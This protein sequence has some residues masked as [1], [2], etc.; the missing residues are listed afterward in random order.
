MSYLW[1]PSCLSQDQKL[2]RQCLLP[3]TYQVKFG[4]FVIFVIFVRLV[5]VTF[6]TFVSTHDYEYDDD[7]VIVH[8]HV[9]LHTDIHISY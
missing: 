4:I 2:A 3:H 9:C 1:Q 6:G 5:L 8:V 7:D